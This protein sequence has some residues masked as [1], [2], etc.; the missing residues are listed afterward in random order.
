M[1]RSSI[2]RALLALVVAASACDMPDD[3]LGDDIAMEVLA[4]D[5]GDD[6]DDDDDSGGTKCGTWGCGSN[7]PVLGEAELGP[8]EVNGKTNDR[9]FVFDPRSF[10]PGRH[11]KREAQLRLVV[12]RGEFVAVDAKGTVQ[13]SGPALAGSTFDVTSEGNE[14]KVGR[15]RIKI[16]NVALVPLWAQDP[17][18][19]SF[20][21]APAYELAVGYREST[22]TERKF[23]CEERSAWGSEHQVY[24]G[25]SAAKYKRWSGEVLRWQDVG[26]WSVLVN[27][28]LYDPKYAEVTTSKEGAPGWFNIACAGGALAKMK[29]LGYDPAPPVGVPVTDWTERQATLKMITARYCGAKSHTVQGLP[30]YWSNRRGWRF[31]SPVSRSRVG[32]V[33]ALWSERGA[34]CIDYT[35]LYTRPEE[36]EVVALL[37]K[38]CGMPSCDELMAQKPQ[39]RFHWKTEVVDRS[40]L[41]GPRP[42]LPDLPPRFP[43]PSVPMP[44]PRPPLPRSP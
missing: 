30:L 14:T 42:S 9:G 13:C 24:E 37:R 36:A 41:A 15:Y 11:C 28:E 3:D 23:L 7:G 44:L 35:R 1:K 31:H 40:D 8:L 6:G 10:L 38:E 21:Y 43:S 25:P 12:E 20:A 29:L 27:G 33:E 18:A 26:Y 39:A 17:S 32:P 2:D 16:A 34:E 4:V 19:R 22:K 5:D